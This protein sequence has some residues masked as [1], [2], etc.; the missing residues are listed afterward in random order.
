M[1]M[2]RMKKQRIDLT[3]DNQRT[4]LEIEVAPEQARAAVTRIGIRAASRF[5]VRQV[6]L[7]TLPAPGQKPEPKKK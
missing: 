3:V 6:V 7:D 2:S 4:P 5:G 1:R